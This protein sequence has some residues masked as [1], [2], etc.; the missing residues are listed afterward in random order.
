L[1]QFLEK[2]IENNEKQKDYYKKYLEKLEEK[3]NKNTAA[4]PQR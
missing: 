3:G 4:P 2:T 1:K